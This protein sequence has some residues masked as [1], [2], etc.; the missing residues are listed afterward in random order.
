MGMNI[1]RARRAV[2]HTRYEPGGRQGHYESFFQRAN[3]PSRPLAFWI[4]YTIFSPKG[5]PYDAVGELWAVYFDGEQEKHTAVKAELPIS[6]CRFSREGLDV[7][8]GESILQPGRMK[9]EVEGKG[10]SISWDLGY[11][12]DEPPLFLLPLRLYEAPLPKAK[13][14]VAKP[15]AVWQGSLRVDGKEIEI[16]GWIGSQ[17]HNWG[18]K[19]TD[20]YAWGQV[21]GFDDAPGSFLEV[22]TAQLK[23]GPVWTPPLTPVVLRHEGVEYAMNSLLHSAWKGRFDYFTWQFRG[24]SAEARLR[25][26]IFG[27]KDAFVGLRYENPPGGWKWCLNSKIASCEVTLERRGQRPVTLR[28]AN[29][30]AFEILTGDDSHGVALRA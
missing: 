23:I 18:S 24:S 9:G 26:R 10:S 29:R 2:N 30:A 19:H 21:A 15:M 8:V 5:R 28:S 25:G 1:D 17:N 16:D 12:G 13:A 4:R 22:A 3:H 14:L 7:K 6:D 27:R 11:Q 20:H